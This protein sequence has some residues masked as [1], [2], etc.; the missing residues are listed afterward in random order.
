M[1]RSRSLV[2]TKEIESLWKDDDDT[3]DSKAFW[4]VFKSNVGVEIDNASDSTYGWL[5]SVYCGIRSKGESMGTDSAS[6]SARVSTFSN[7]VFPDR[8]VKPLK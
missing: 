8:N 1:F 7:F 6:I 5:D 2:G 4:G 3:H